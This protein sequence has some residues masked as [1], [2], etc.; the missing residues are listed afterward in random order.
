MNKREFISALYQHYTTPPE[1]V[2]PQ[3]KIGASLFLV[4]LVII[5]GAYQ[6]LEPSIIQEAFT[7]VGLIIIVG[8]FLTAMMAQVR[9]LIGRLLRFFF[10]KPDID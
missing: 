1:E 10:E 3:F 8:G 5:Y 4:G 9:M 2:F 7:L 6:L